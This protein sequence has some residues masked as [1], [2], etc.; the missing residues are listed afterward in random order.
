MSS[1][2]PTNLPLAHL[3]CLRRF[4]QITTI[5]KIVNAFLDH[6][7]QPIRNFLHTFFEILF[8]KV[9]FLSNI[10][11]ANRKIKIDLSI[12][13]LEIFCTPY[14]SFLVAQFE[15]ILAVP[16]LLWSLS[17]ILYF[18]I[19]VTLQF[20]DDEFSHDEISL[21][22]LN[23]KLYIRNVLPAKINQI[24]INSKSNFYNDER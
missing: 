6:F 9:F 16:L 23:Y 18:Q 21:L 24:F 17:N 14:Y 20:I 12:T 22:C 7:Q 19:K 1:S 8:L 4:C 5:K 11:T 15:V 10:S 3:F 13:I 2:I